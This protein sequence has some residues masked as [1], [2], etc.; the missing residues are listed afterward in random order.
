[1]KAVG[2]EWLVYLGMGANLPSWAGP[3][4]ETL[5]AAV[6]AMEELGTVEAG[7]GL[8]RTEP[9]G[10]VPDQPAFVNGAVLL[11][12]RLEPRTLLA[13]LHT[14]ECRFGRVREGIP[15]MG[16][17]TLDLDILLLVR[18]GEPVGWVE[19]GLRVPHPEMHRRRFVLAPLAEI[20]GDAVHPESGKTVRQLL[21]SLSGGERVERLHAPVLQGTSRNLDLKRGSR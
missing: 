4:E 7:S 15:E 9:V 19:Q 12:T 6:R 2:D 8:W 20:A 5:R 18:N 13:G 11:R 14:I 3:P 16:P 10:P 1:M 17:R 21:E